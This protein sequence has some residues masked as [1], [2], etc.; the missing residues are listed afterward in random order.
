MCEQ[1]KVDDLRIL[2]ES[3]SKNGNGD[4]SIFIGNYPLLGDAVNIDFMKNEMRINNTYYDEQMVEAMRKMRETI[5]NACTQYIK[6]C[7]K[8][9]EKE[10]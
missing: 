9:G 2:L 6:D 10:E 4:M 5:T 3:L 7:Y 8:A 1:V